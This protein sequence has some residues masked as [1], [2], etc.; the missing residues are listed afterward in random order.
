M[1]KFRSALLVLALAMIAAGGSAL[2][3]PWDIASAVLAVM[4]GAIWLLMFAVQRAGAR[5]SCGV[6][7]ELS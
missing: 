4:M 1:Q 2:R 5:R 7:S 6:H 3:A